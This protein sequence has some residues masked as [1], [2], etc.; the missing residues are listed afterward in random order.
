M[1]ILMNCTGK[2]R[3]GINRRVYEMTSYV[4]TANLHELIIV[5]LDC[6]HKTEFEKNG[7]VKQYWI[8]MK[9]WQR[10]APWIAT[11]QA[12]KISS[13]SLTFEQHVAKT[14]ED[15][16][17]IITIEKPDI[18][19]VQA[20]FQFAWC[21]IIAAHKT[22]LPIVHL[23]SGSSQ[24]E[25]FDPKLRSKYFSLEKKY[26][27]FAHATI[28][29]SFLARETLQRILGMDF[30]D[31]TVIYN[32]FSNQHKCNYKKLPE[33][34]IL[35]WVGRNAEVKNIDY[36]L[37]MRRCLPE[38]VPI[39][40][41]CD[42]ESDSDLKQRLQSCGIITINTMHPSRMGRFYKSIS[43]LL[44]T[45]HFE[46]FSNVTAE[47][48][49]AGCVTIVPPT[50]GLAELFIENGLQELVTKLNDIEHVANLV[51]NSY[52][53][54]QPIRRLSEKL[55]RSN[56]WNHVITKYFSEFENV[57]CTSL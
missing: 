6:V 22:G 46:F 49:A 40:C 5:G 41:I 53:F 18:C 7:N 24:M 57:K 23:F 31:A 2:Q 36:L 1:K 8:P 52:R 15:I 3:G 38:K 12:Y 29:N 26:A 32:G 21:L 42:L 35:G 47:A 20:S 45:S 55:I 50:S 16:Q 4:N 54:E 11:K 39:R 27:A 10:I 17:E 30:S 56:S 14:C 9:D 34:V 43:C 37:M 28:F 13:D 25:V 48:L 19:F 33:K 44:S 51:I